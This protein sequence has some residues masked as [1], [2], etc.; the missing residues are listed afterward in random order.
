MYNIVLTIA[1]DGTDFV[2]WQKTD[3][4]FEQFPSIAET[5]ERV[6]I[7]IFGHPISLQ[8][9][10]R[11]D[12][13]VHAFGQVVHFITEKKCDTKRLHISLNALLSNTIRVRHVEHAKNPNFHPT[14]DACKKEYHYHIA[15]GQ[16]LLPFQRFTH[17]HYPKPLDIAAMKQASTLFIGTHDFKAFRNFRKGLD[18]DDTIRSIEDI[19]ILENDSIENDSD[20][21]KIV[22]LGD[23]FLY[24]M[25][26]NITGTLVYVGANKMSVDDCAKLL[27]KGSRVD[28][29]ICAPA[30]GLTLYKVYYE[31]YE[32]GIQQQRSTSPHRKKCLVP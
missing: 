13:G 30:H 29:G 32:L 14:L 1:Y 23:N 7:K 4:D 3:L 12:R 20:T 9:A 10:S 22:L 28:A 26:R 21:L 6:L 17:W 19:Q 31:K 2:G 8:A 11:T 27:T 16:T 5:L 24:K 15:R 18:T 25:V